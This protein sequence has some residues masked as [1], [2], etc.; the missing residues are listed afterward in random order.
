METQTTKYIDAQRVIISHLLCDAQEGSDRTIRQLTDEVG[1]SSAAMGNFHFRMAYE[2]VQGL[3]ARHAVA[4]GQQ[5]PGLPEILMEIEEKYRT[6]GHAHNAHTLLADWRAKAGNVKRQGS[7]VDAANILMK[8]AIRDAVRSELPGFQERLRKAYDPTEEV[9]GFAYYLLGLSESTQKPA[10]LS[11]ILEKA[12]FA[13]ATSTGYPWLDRNVFWN[14]FTNSGG[15]TQECV[16]IWMAPSGHGKTSAATSFAT[17]QV[18]QGNPVVFLS[19]EESVENVSLRLYSALTGLQPYAV[20]NPSGE[21]EEAAVE[22]VRPIADKLVY[23]YSIAGDLGDIETKIRRHRTQFG[24]DKPLLVIVDHISALDSGSGNWSRD[25]ENVTKGLK[26]IAGRL[27]PT[28][29]VFSQVP[30]KMETQLRAKNYTTLAD[31]RGSRGVRNWADYM[32]VSC[33]HRDMDATV[34]QLLKNRYDSARR[35][36]GMYQFDR[37]L[38]IIGDELLEST[39]P[40]DADA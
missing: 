25:L 9:A 6:N 35:V 28:L 16:V 18:E 29:L 39:F 34:I 31:A 40:L 33:R 2:A 36:W 26:Q 3:Y 11:R 4:Q 19:A 15:W 7:P 37:D 13:R 10:S 1:L 23:A 8:E 12:K 24:G 14:R 22:Y 30:E 32:V 21:E 20:L 27:Q 17:K 5:P 38:S